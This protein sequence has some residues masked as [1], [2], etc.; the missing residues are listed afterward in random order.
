MKSLLVRA[1]HRRRTSQCHGQSAVLP[2]DRD[3]HLG[4]E[5]PPKTRPRT[6]I[7]G[8]R[9][10]RLTP[11]MAPSLRLTTASTATRAAK[12]AALF[13]ASEVAD[14]QGHRDVRH[15]KALAQSASR[16]DEVC[17]RRRGT[18]P[19]ESVVRPISLRLRSV[20]ASPRGQTEPWLQPRI[21]GLTL[22]RDGSRQ[23]I[24]P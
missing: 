20:S 3:M 13:H 1:K 21:D 9:G 16:T 18:T 7:G 19:P 10:G 4:R 2:D 17:D 24:L 5:R 8:G 22:Q 11:Q 12:S 23:S 15:A 6:E 14:C